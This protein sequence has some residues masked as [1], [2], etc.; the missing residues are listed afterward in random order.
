MVL[1]LKFSLQH[2]LQ[3]GTYNSDLHFSKMRSTKNQTSFEVEIS[4]FESYMT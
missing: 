4:S 2:K 1:F 3:R